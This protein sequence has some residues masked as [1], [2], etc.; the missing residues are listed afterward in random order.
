MISVTLLTKNSQKYL[1]KV[2]QA[3]AVFPEVVVLDSGSTD[4]TLETAKA[5]PNVSLHHSP[6]FDGFGP[7]HNKATNLARHDWIL[8]IDSDEMVSAELGQEILAM[9]L[10][11]RC[12]YSISRHNYYNGKHIRWCGWYP[13]RQYRLYHRKQTCFTD[14]QVHEAVITQGMK[15]VPLQA[16]LFHYSYETTADFLTKMQQYSELFASQHQGKKRSSLGK[17]LLHGSFSFFKSYVLQR[18]FLGGR[19]GF[20]ISV[21]QGNTAFYKYLKLEEKNKSHTQH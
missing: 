14:A 16:P 20:V 15:I 11:P 18:G 13:D 6:T 17:A 2:L 21:Y 1:S 5:F 4:N 12:V 3:L 19:E 7:M 10:D 9:K 8:S